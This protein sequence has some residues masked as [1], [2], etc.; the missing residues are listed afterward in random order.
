[1]PLE[2]A[3]RRMT[4]LAAAHMGIEDRGRSAPGMFADLVLFDPATVADRAT[5]REPHLTSVGISR[6]WVNGLE[7]YAN[8]TPTGAR[9]GHII[10][11]R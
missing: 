9:P 7:V 4:A 6:V 11:K 2:E 5:P 8:G 3:V 1:M 10:R